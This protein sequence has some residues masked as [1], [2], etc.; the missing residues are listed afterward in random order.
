MTSSEWN[1]YYRALKWLNLKLANELNDK[2]IRMIEEIE[3]L[4][5]AKQSD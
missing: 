2:I 4:K 1:V 5:N 3:E